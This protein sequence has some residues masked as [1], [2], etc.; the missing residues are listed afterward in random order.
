MDKPEL[1]SSK[2]RRLKGNLTEMFKFINDP[3]TLKRKDQF[4]LKDRPETI[5]LRWED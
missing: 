2:L 5:E 4:P 1:F 3:D